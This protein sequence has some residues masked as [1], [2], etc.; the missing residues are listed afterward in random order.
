MKAAYLAYDR[1]S[2]VGLSV[3][4]NYFEQV[5]FYLVDKDRQPESVSFGDLSILT[6]HV[7]IPSEEGLRTLAHMKILKS[8]QDELRF[9]RQQLSVDFRKSPAIYTEVQK[10]CRTEIT[11][12]NSI[13]DIVFSPKTNE[14]YIEKENMGVTA[15]QYL[16][17][18][19]HQIVAE[20]FG[21]FS[22]N[23]FKTAPE[24]SH[25]WFSAEFVYEMQK[26]RNGHLGRKEFILVKDRQNKSVLDNWYFIRT[27]ENKIVVHQWVPFN[28]F[29]NSDFQKF[30]IE[31]IEKFLK[32]KLE[33]VH[34]TQL[35]H[36]YVNS[37]SGFVNQNSKLKHT[38]ISN[39]L[40]SFH[41]WPREMIN[42][43]LYTKLDLKMKELNKLQ[44]AMQ[45]V[46]G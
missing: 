36:F 7:M 41:F 44:L 40:P 30:I 16:F 27:S 19:D 4:S 32:E 5:D 45:N 31:R 34:L 15:Y 8:M 6:E 33:L 20:N 24:N 2:L 21:G 17:V 46:R 43:Y 37:T 3:L 22:K 23:I 10:T 9:Y 11:S 35:N 26:P 13:K 42:R 38:K 29:K 1:N 14:V 25:V 28:Q 39:V 12:L 18:E